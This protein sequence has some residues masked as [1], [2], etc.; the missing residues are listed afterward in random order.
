MALLSSLRRFLANRSARRRSAPA[1]RPSFRP[2]LEGLEDRLAPAAFTVIDNIDSAMDTGSLRY[3]L[4]NLSTGTSASTNTITFASNLAGQT[5]TEAAADG[6]TLTITQGVTIT[7][8]SGGVTVDGGSQFTA[9]TVNPG[10]TATLSGLTIAHGS[11]IDGGGIINSG[12]LAVG[13]STFSGNIGGGIYNTGMLTVS[14]ST[15]AS[16]IG[17]TFSGL[18]I[19]GNPYTAKVGSG[20]DNYDGGMATVS[21]STFS[22]NTGSGIFNY[23]DPSVGSTPTVSVSDSTFSGNQAA[24]GGGIWNY[25]GMVQVSDSTFSDLRFALLGA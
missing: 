24:A 21:G 2:R 9:F 10:V 13:H 7:G 12:T 25:G 4:A 23:Y 5:I 8:P 22:N 16:N 19:G 20:I 17:A 15:F 1:R 11:G 3:A 6:G 14:N 18:D